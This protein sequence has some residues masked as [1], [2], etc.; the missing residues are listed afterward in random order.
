M[1]VAL[2]GLVI[3]SWSAAAVGAV[4]MVSFGFVWV[5]DAVTGGEST[6]EVVEAAE[7]AAVDVVD[8]EDPEL[9]RRGTFLG[10]ATLGLGG[11]ITG[12]VALPVAG[13]AVL[14]AF[15]GQGHDDVDIGPIEDYPEGDFVVA[16]FLSDPEAGEV[17]RRTAYVRNNG[18]KDGVPS[19]TILSNRCVHLGCPVQV[20]GLSL[21][22]QKQLVKVD[23]GAPVSLTP[24]KAASGFGCPCHGGQYDTEGNR[25]AG[26]PVRALDRYRFLIRDGRL[27]LTEP[28]SVGEVDGTGSEAVIHAYDW[29]NPS[30]HV[31]GPESIL[32]PLEPPN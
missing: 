27:V 2:V 13:F 7:P 24:T 8:E 5:R 19:F 21:E 14:P 18:L 3:G 16:T 26:P 25:V 6:T 28:Y 17:S 1:A 10:L 22:D 30:V 20:N 4:L 32:Y 15:V 23:G 31:D 12:M 9:Y 29:V 11:V